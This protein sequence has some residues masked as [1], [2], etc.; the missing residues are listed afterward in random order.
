MV[1]S[2][3]VEVSVSADTDSNATAG[4]TE[5]SSHVLTLEGNKAL[6]FLSLFGDAY[7]LVAVGVMANVV[8]G[9]ASTQAT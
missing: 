8:R 4:A 6:K 9:V 2:Y 5:P 1:S 3:M 7:A